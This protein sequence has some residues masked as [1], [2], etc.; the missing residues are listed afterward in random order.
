MKY[1]RLF[2]TASERAAATI[3]KPCVAYTVETDSL[4]FLADNVIE[5]EDMTTKA[6]LVS[7]FDRDGDGELTFAEAAAVTNEQFAEI[8]EGSLGS[9]FNEFRYFTGVTSTP[10]NNARNTTTQLGYG[11]FKGVAE[12]T[13]PPSLL[14][15]GSFSFQS[16]NNMKVILNDGLQS[17]GGSMFYYSGS[18]NAGI[19]NDSGVDISNYGGMLTIPST[20]TQIGDSLHSATNFFS[21]SGRFCVLKLLPTT[22]PTLIGNIGNNYAKHILVPPG[23][24]NTYQSAEGWSGLADYIVEWVR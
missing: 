13:T 7:L 11:I 22:P 19:P 16:G 18:V 2:E 21:Y 12:L 17:L 14:H 20:V 4:E 5:F 10:D 1:I 3:E 23:T 8:P 9:K 24:L 15:L 6:T